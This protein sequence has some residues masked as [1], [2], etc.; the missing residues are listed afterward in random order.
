MDTSTKKSSVS[1]LPLDEL[2]GTSKL[3]HG[4]QQAPESLESMA[5]ENLAPTYFCHVFNVSNVDQKVPKGNRSYFLPGVKADSPWVAGPKFLTGIQYTIGAKIPSVLVDTYI[6]MEGKRHI[7]KINGEAMAKD[8]LYP[9]YGPICDN[10]D[11]RMWGCGYFKRLPNEAPVP[12]YEEL[13][14]VFERYNET[15]KAWLDDADMIA[16]SGHARINAMHVRA[17][18][19]LK[20]ERG[21]AK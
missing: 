3:P 5:C 4:V 12:T 16:D 14:P 6:G 19:W 17:A 7:I 2:L 10:N 15:M 8:I 21:W 13:L 20:A 11:L 1:E 18:K 9:G